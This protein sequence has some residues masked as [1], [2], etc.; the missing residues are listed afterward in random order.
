MSIITDTIKVVNPDQVPIDVCD[1]PVYALSKEIQYRFNEKFGQ[2]KYFVL[3]GGLH[4]EKS[5][6]VLHGNLIN[7]TG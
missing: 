1:Q 2:G 6:L 3:F 4:I 5:F 7:G